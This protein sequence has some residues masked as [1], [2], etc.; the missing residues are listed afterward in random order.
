MKRSPFLGML[1]ALAAWF[2]HLAGAGQHAAAATANTNAEDA[3][4]KRL[5]AD[6]DVERDGSDSSCSESVDGCTGGGAFRP[7]SS[8][9]PKE[10]IAGQR[11][12]ANP[13]QTFH[14]FD[15][16][17]PGSHQHHQQQ[18][19]HHHHTQVHHQAQVTGAGHAHLQQQQQQQQ[20]QKQQQQQAQ[21]DQ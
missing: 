5:K 7:T 20:Q 8:G 6:A 1:A 19:H 14:A 9:G 11:A 2:N 15:A 17:T 18:Q 13:C 10:A 12:A 3:L 16:V 21:A 4:R